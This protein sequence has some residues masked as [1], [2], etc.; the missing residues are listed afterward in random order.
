MQS[1][2][3]AAALLPSLSFLLYT[4]YFF[5]APDHP[6]SLFP[7]SFSKK[8]DIITVRKTAKFSFVFPCRATV[9]LKTSLDV[10]TFTSLNCG[11]FP[12][13]LPLVNTRS[14]RWLMELCSR[15]QNPGP[16]WEGEGCQIQ[17]AHSLGAGVRGNSR[18]PATCGTALPC[19]TLPCSISLHLGCGQLWFSDS[20]RLCSSH[21]G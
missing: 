7:S 12:S 8:C 13:L 21:S 16:H 15:Q 2:Q 6:S 10:L 11:S 9:Q 4:S 5:K 17:A 1:Q 18:L 20:S 19:C 14:S 3:H